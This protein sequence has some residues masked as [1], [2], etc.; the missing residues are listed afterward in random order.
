MT[1]IVQPQTPRQKPLPCTLDELQKIEVRVI[2]KGLVVRLMPGYTQE[3]ISHLPLM[4]IAHFACHAQQNA[5]SPLDSTL[6]L[7]D[8]EL[9][10]LQIMQ[11]PMPGAALV[12]LSV[13]ETAMGDEQLPDE[14]IHLGTT[15]L[16]AGFQGVIATMWWVALHIE[17]S[18]EGF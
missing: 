18:K 13:C 6:V 9:R 7:Q 2:N 1:V 10:L 8:G 15:L 4:S 5:Q 12:F 17:K 11:W 16:F 3:V 14:V